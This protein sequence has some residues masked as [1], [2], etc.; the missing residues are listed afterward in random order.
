MIRH[1][2]IIAALRALWGP[3][4]RFD[5]SKLNMKSGGFGSP[6]EWDQDWTF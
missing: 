1:P 4:I 2:R 6:V 5:Q 3:N